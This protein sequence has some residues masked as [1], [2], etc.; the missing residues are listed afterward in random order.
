M[1]FILKD[2]VGLLRLFYIIRWHNG[3]EIRTIKLCF[4]G[5]L[6][7]FTNLYFQFWHGHKSELLF[8]IAV[9]ADDMTAAFATVAFVA[10]IS[11]LVDRT[12]TASQYALLASIGTIGRNL[13]IIIRS[14][15]RLAKR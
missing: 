2:L 13:C 7:G 4:C 6:N 9:I 11:L 14:P 1:Q 8:A 15:N 10:F 3:N 12:Y 5:D